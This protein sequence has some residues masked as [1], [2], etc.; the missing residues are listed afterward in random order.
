MNKTLR[1]LSCLALLTCMLQAE[2][3]DLNISNDA[4]A[5]AAQIGLPRYPGSTLRGVDGQRDKAFSLGFTVPGGRV[6]TS[7]LQL[8]VKDAPSR[9]ATF[10]ESTL[11][12]YGPVLVCG[13]GRPQPAAK[14]RDA[15]DCTEVSN[16]ADEHV[17]KAGKRQDARIVVIRR[18]GATTQIDLLR[19]IDTVPR[20]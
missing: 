12:A 3:A 7:M 16:S 13:Q 4:A 1:A 5:T 19:V 14:E 11:Q 17:L 10:Y 20:Q 18:S 15:L 9:V 8:E 6:Q 2:A